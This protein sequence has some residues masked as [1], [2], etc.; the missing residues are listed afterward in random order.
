M[1]VKSILEYKR[2]YDC[3]L[4]PNCDTENSFVIGRCAVCGYKK[5]MSVAVLKSW[6][7]VEEGSDID[8]ISFKDESV[9]VTDNERNIRKVIIVIVIIAVVIGIFVLIKR[10]N[11][12]LT[13]HSNSFERTSVKCLSTVTSSMP[14]AAD[15][16]INNMLQDW[17]IKVDL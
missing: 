13:S 14:L 4:C 1:E 12:Y 11:T 17:G 2:E 10:W 15:G 16:G 7:D 5:D 6:T 9:E 8:N 3:W